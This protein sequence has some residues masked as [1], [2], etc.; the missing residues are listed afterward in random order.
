MQGIRVVDL[1][2]MIAGPMATTVLCDQGADVIKVEPPGI[3][4][5]MRHLGATRNGISGLYHSTNRGK[6][7]L[8]VDMKSPEGRAVV[9]D[10]ASTADVV[11]QNFRPGVAERL[12]VDYETLSALNSRLV[13]LSVCGFGDRGPMAH[14]SAYDNV[15]QAFAG[16]AQSQADPKTG[17]PI[18]YY[19]LF[20]D[21]VTALTGAQAV[22]AALFARERGEA[23]QHIRL[24][25]AD[26]AVS[27]LW[28]DVAN[29]ASFV[30]EGASPGMTISKGVRL[31]KFADGYGTAAPVTDAQFHGYCRAFGIDSSDPRFATVMDR[32]AN[33]DALADLMGNV[34]THAA[35]MDLASAIAA[36]EAEDV[37]C[38]AAMELADLPEHP[39]M[40]ANDS[41]ARVEHPVGG[42][43]VEPNNPPNFSGTP[44]AP[45]RPAA[46]LGE[47]TDAILREIGRSE[48]QITALRNQRAVA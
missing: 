16:V 13:Y 1:G 22:S 28:A 45:L 25:M 3:G 12:G 30:G 20:C 35:E 15:I 24:S 34:L 19:Q 9:Q 39:Q 26:S 47:H 2:A 37:P 44:S 11:V 36:L 42:T 41:F 32:N 33:G 29:V 46:A 31:I 6:R 10:L 17:E 27:F 7:S 38:A 5:V 14:K 21:K 48:E 8:A 4:D 18:Q 23:G 40:M 43:L